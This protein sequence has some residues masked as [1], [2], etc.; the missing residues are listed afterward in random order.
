MLSFDRLCFSWA[1][2]N[3]CL[4]DITLQIASGEQVAIVGD[5][6]A[7]KSTLLRLAAGLLAPTSGT[8]SW[9]QQDL[10]EQRALARAKQ[11][12]FLFQES[13]RQLFHSRVDD[14]IAFG[15]RLQ[16][17]PGEEIRARVAA[18]LAQCELTAW[19]TS[20]PLD[21]DAGQRRMVAVACLHAMQPAL[22][23]LD[24]PSRDFDPHWLAILERWLA[25]ERAKGTTIVAISHDAEFVRRNFTTLVELKAGRLVAHGPAAERLSALNGYHQDEK[26]S[27]LLLATLTK[28]EHP[29]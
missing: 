13:E 1:P 10:R 26:S 9:Q 7:G 20:H 23:L 21:L 4:H 27:A 15:L 14:E 11:I 24:E 29:R 28:A 12:G 17:R 5:N 2:D 6:G 16:K 25:S 3:P 18:A 8:V 22:L 19:A